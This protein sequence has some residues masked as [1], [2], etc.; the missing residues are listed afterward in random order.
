MFRGTRKMTVSEFLES[1][2]G[3]WF[4]ATPA[5]PEQIAKLVEE[6]GLTLPADYLDYLGQSNGG[7]GFLEVQPCYLRIWNVESV[8]K[9]NLDYRMPEF[10]P[11][12]FA[13][14]DAGGGEFFAF[15]TRPSPPWPI[16]SIPF[17]PM[18]AD[19]ASP[20]ASNFLELLEHAVPPSR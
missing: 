7:E 11:G 10:V 12:F 8:V 6:S 14:G 1:C 3:K 5:S 13:F 20:V 9:N 2:E 4:P 17:V 19:S 15:D 18:D 16:V